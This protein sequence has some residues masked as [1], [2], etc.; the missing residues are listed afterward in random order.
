MRSTLIALLIAVAGA[1]SA[2]FELVLALDYTNGLVHRIDGENSIYMGSFGGNRLVSPTGLAVQQSTNRVHVYD[3]VLRSV[4]S[5][6][7]NTGEQVAEV[8]INAGGFA[9]LSLANNGDFLVT[10]FSSLS[11]RRFSQSGTLQATFT[12]PAGSVGGRAIMQAPDGNY[13]VAWSGSSVISRHNAAGTLLGTAVSA[14]PGINDTRQM[15]IQN[16]QVVI[17]GGGSGKWMKATYSSSGLWGSPIETSAFTYTYGASGGHLNT[18]YVGGYNTSATGL[19]S[20]Y[21]MTSGTLTSTFTIPGAGSI[22][23]VGTVVAPEPG[24]WA[25]MGLGAMTLIRRRRRR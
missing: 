11:S 9:Q 7:Y 3:S 14:T 18:I 23:A 17:S 13:Y 22:A 5:F 21:H 2:S 10:D 16:N 4:L 6:D 20:S 15:F 25:A 24:T 8:A 12:A 19:L 1:A